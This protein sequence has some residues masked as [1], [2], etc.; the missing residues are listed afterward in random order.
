MRYLT[1]EAVDQVFAQ[2]DGSGK[3][4]WLLT[5]HLGTVRDLVDSSG[6]VV[7]HITY[8]SFGNVVAQSHPEFST[9]F[10][11]A[12][13]E[14][15]AQTGLYYDRARYY[16]PRLGRF[17]SEDPTGFAAGPNLY[18][19]VHNNPVSRIDPRGTEDTPAD[20]PVSSPDPAAPQAASIPDPP[21][22]EAVPLSDFPQPQTSVLIDVPTSDVTPTFEASGTKPPPL[23]EFGEFDETPTGPPPPGTPTVIDIYTPDQIEERVRQPV[24]DPANGEDDIPT[25]PNIRPTDTSET[26]ASRD[27]PSTERDQL[28]EE[29]AKVLAEFVAAVAVIGA[30]AF[31]L[32]PEVVPLLLDELPVLGPAAAG[33]AAG[34]GR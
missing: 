25:D 5:D 2:E 30:V 32:G 23:P 8:D 15:D 29:E 1:G 4:L 9:R 27:K 34:A 16:D 17:L 7:N 19:Y 11:F 28:T 33:V 10:L 31:L 18:R 6:T 13:R 22:P 20:E 21:A 12:G 24:R 26:A 14:F 3:L